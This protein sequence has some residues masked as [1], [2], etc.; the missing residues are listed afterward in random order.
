MKKIVLLICLL[1]M[2]SCSSDSDNVI[3]QPVVTPPTQDFLI[4]DG[5]AVNISGVS[6]YYVNDNHYQVQVGNDAYFVHI[7]F[8]KYGNLMSI[9]VASGSGWGTI[10]WG[11]FAYY[12][13]HYFDFEMS[14][15]DPNTGNCT[16]DFSG[17]LYRDKYDL[18]SDTKTIN[19]H[20]SITAPTPSTSLGWS[21]NKG[22]HANADGDHWFTDEPL[23]QTFES[24]TDFTDVYFVSDDQYRLVFNLSGTQT[25]NGTYAFAPATAHHCI[26]VEKFNTQTL[27]YESWSTTGTMQVTD[28]LE[29][30]Q[31][32]FY[33]NGNFSL[34]AANPND[35]GE[36]VHFSNGVFNGLRY[37][38]N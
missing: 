3:P 27:Q 25:V 37:N 34:T 17:T 28:K 22:I 13:A 21:P 30:F 15:I 12:N 35:P 7:Y 5:Q 14:P 9:N 19:G 18:N 1:G 10:N 24:G 6:D 36:T 20:I 4:I 32:V 26:K 2:F 33:L 11:N 23:H 29:A 38:S 16:I 8:S 31:G